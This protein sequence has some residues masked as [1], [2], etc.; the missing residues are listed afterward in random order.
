V[1]A[2]RY[3]APL[4]PGDRVGVTAPSSGV[5]AALR[6]RLEFAVQVVRDR[7]Y[8]VVE[9]GCLHGDGIVSAPAADRAAELQAMLTDPAIRAVVPPWGG[10]LAVELLPLLDLEAIAAAEPTWLVGYSD[11]STLLVPLTACAGIATLHAT[12]LLDTPYALPAPLKPWHEVAATPAG[13][14]VEQGPSP[15]H[16][17]GG[18]DDWEREPDITRPREDMPTR[19]RRLDAEGPLHARGRLIGGCIETVSVL[20]GTPFGDVSALAADGLIVYVEASEQPALDIARGL[21]RLRLGGWFDAAAA[22]LVG[23]THAPSSGDFTQQD[24]VR[25]AL[26]GLGVPAVLDV[27]CGHVP[28]QLSLVN[29]AL[30]ELTVDAAAARLTQR[31]I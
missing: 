22:V 31:L 4:R 6:P 1:P 30:A 14:T 25:S 5:P 8:E 2:I 20:A 16:R 7:G 26:D 29:G 11:L 24:A 28:P 18:Y 21:W 17:S 27:D 15:S 9:G 3:P 13:G 23:R 19:W 10:E 12:N